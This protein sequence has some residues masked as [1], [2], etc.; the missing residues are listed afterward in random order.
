MAFLYIWEFSEVL[1]LSDKLMAANAPG[2]LQQAPVAIGAS[3]ASSQP[4][5]GATKFIRVNTDSICSI[6]IGPSPQ[7]A[8]ASNAR[9]S[10]GSTEYFAVAPSHVLSVITNPS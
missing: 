2:I 8:T 1:V 3:A 5:T 9:M 7:T 10:A 4:F 6:V